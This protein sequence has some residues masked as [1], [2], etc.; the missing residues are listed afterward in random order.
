MNANNKIALGSVQFGTNYGVANT[1]GRV[2]MEMAGAILR[3]AQL[4]G[5]DTVDTAIAYGDS[6]SVLGGL[7]VQ[8]WKV[9]SK[10][11]GVPEECSDVTC[12]VRTQMQESLQR[13]GLKRMHGLLLHHPRQLFEGVGSD[14]Y[15]ALQS[16]KDEGLV[17]KVGVS[18]YGPAE[19]EYIWPKYRF[20]LVQAPLNILDRRFVD[21]GWAS[22]LKNSGVEVHTRSTFLQG[23]LLMPADKRPDRF[24]RWSDIWHIWDRWLFDTGLT[25][26]Q[27]CLRY[28]ITLS[29]IDRVIVGV[30]TVTQLHEI[31]SA[32]AGVLDSIP[33]FNHLHDDR[34]INP[35]SWSQL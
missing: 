5:M 6:E 24:N 35:A 10:L 26:L 19:L 17:A 21:S 31:G 2:S 9:V 4:S 16:L 20:D 28:A 32:A 29:V 14:L 25:P 13:L 12:W 33:V 22:R 34:L 3:K 18:V 8:E 7:G 15:A 11:P 23:L 27:A 30:D 1:I